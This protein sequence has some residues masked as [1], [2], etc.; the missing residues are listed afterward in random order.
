MEHVLLLMRVIVM[1]DGMAIS[2]VIRLNALLWI[3]VQPMETVLL[4]MRVIVML[5]GMAILNV[6]RLNALV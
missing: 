6:M 1:L 4:L 2:I 3:I 5:D